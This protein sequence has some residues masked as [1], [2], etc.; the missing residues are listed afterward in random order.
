ML[1]VAMSV[2]YSSHTAQ[3]NVI[4]NICAINKSVVRCYNNVTFTLKMVM[5]AYTKM[6]EQLQQMTW[7]ET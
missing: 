6:L 1:Y 4:V 5:A 3:N 7:L 2:P